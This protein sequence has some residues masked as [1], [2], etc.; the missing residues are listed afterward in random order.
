MG[1][2]KKSRPAKLPGL[3][4]AQSRQMERK[5]FDQLV[6]AEAYKLL[7]EQ[8]D[9]LLQQSADAFYMAAADM[10]HMGPGR[11]ERFGQLAMQ[12]LDEIATLINSDYEDDKA[13]TYSIAKID[14]RMKQICG[15]KFEPWEVRYGKR[16]RICEPGDQS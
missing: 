8:C 12:Y 4:L 11:C 2:G 13:L 14:R 3:N 16:K 15:D 10:F 6:H 7:Q 5:L 1:K 9:N